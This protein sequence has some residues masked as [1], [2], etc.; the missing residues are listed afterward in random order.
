MRHSSAWTMS[1]TIMEKL[2]ASAAKKVAGSA[3]SALLL[4]GFSVAMG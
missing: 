1:L 3:R 4:T 2:Q